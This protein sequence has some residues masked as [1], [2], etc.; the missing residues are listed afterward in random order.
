[1]GKPNLF[2]SIGKGLGNVG[3]DIG[4]AGKSSGKWIG[5]AA[6]DTFHWSEKTIGNVGNRVLN[7]ADD[8]LSK[9][10]DIFNNPMLLM[11]AGAVIV[12]IIV[13]K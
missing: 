5:H 1:M 13:L 6:E 8:Q 9:F 2:K 10:T 3:K 12:A 11:V 7:F 4:K